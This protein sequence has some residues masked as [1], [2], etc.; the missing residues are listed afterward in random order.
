MAFSVG[1][2]TE[3]LFQALG[4]PNHLRESGLNYPFG[5]RIVYDLDRHIALIIYPTHHGYY[6]DEYRNLWIN[7]QI[8]SIL[9]RPKGVDIPDGNITVTL[10]DPDFALEDNFLKTVIEQAFCTHFQIEKCPYIIKIQG[11]CPQPRSP[12]ELVRYLNK[13]VILLEGDYRFAI[14]HFVPFCVRG[15]EFEPFITNLEQNSWR[16]LSVQAKTLLESALA[17]EAVME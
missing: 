14:K 3:M 4:L 1:T 13:L 11:R 5:R 16:G 17:Y 6:P 7:G 2:C 15:N 8:L 12:D 10:P 9:E